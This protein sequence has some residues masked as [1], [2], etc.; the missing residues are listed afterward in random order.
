M[1]KITNDGLTRSGTVLYSC[2]HM[3]RVGV[4]SNVVCFASVKRLAMLIVNCLP[5]YLSC[6]ECDVN[7]Y[8]T[9]LKP[10]SIDR[11]IYMELST[12]QKRQNAVKTILFA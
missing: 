12:R 11:F 2:T 1:S 4:K 9:Q 3:T 5:N 7:P 8:S 10:P 6:V